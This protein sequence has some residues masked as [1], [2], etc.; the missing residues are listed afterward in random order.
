[1]TARKKGAKLSAYDRALRAWRRRHAGALLE[2]ERNARG[3]SLRQLGERCE[4]GY[5]YLYRVE[6]GDIPV[7]TTVAQLVGEVLGAPDLERALVRAQQPVPEDVLVLL[8]KSPKLL[9]RLEGRAKVKKK[10]G[11]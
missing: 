5:T 9:A 3:V 7:S 1:V 6:R 8:L 11:V 2:V 4:V 10:G